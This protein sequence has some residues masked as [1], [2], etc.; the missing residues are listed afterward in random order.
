[1]W[2]LDTIE[3]WVIEI[4]GSDNFKLFVEILILLYWM[5]FPGQRALSSIQIATVSVKFNVAFSE[6][7]KQM[8]MTN[9]A[10]MT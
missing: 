2:Y 10:C 7:V 1:M 3:Y 4:H 9:S 8:K 6:N 5:V